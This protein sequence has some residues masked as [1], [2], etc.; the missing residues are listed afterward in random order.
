MARL[1]FCKPDREAERRACQVMLQEM[2]EM[3]RRMGFMPA[4]HQHAE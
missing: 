2:D 1:R 3:N 4:V